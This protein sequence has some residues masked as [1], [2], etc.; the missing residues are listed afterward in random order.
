[1]V[2]VMHFS[3]IMTYLTGPFQKMGL[4]DSKTETWSK[5]VPSKREENIFICLLSLFPISLNYPK[6][7]KTCCSCLHTPLRWWRKIVNVTH[8]IM[9]WQLNGS[10][11]TNF[12][13]HVTRQRNSWLSKQT[14]LFLLNSNEIFWELLDVDAVHL[15]TTWEWSQERSNLVYKPKK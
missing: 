10:S 6:S 11:Q 5:N 15:F 9:S 14:C 1:M 3:N 2:W 13:C 4:S 7:Y 8:F 12:L